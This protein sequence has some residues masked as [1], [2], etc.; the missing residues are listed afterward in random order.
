MIPAE[1]VTICRDLEDNAVLDAALAG[2][3]G[4]VVSGDHDLLTLGEFWRMSIITPSP[5]CGLAPFANVRA[6][7]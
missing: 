4:C 2:R 5:V 3:A 7:V 1:A 6:P